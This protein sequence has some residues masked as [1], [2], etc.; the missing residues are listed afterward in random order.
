MANYTARWDNVAYTV[1]KNDQT[2][3]MLRGPAVCRI[4]LT[5]DKGECARWTVSTSTSTTRSTTRL[6]TTNRPSAAHLIVANMFFV[7]VAIGIALSF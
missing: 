1:S 2:L 3:T 4:T 5:C 7:A 6:V